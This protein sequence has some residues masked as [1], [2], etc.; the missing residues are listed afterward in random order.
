MKTVSFANHLQSKLRPISLSP[1]SN[2][3]L[4]STSHFSAKSRLTPSLRQ[5]RDKKPEEDIVSLKER[6]NSLLKQQRLDKRRIELLEKTVE[7]LEAK[8]QNMKDLLRNTMETERNHAGDVHALYQTL[9]ITDL[10]QQIEDLTQTSV[11]YRQRHHQAQQEIE[12]VKKTNFHYKNTIKRYR[13][14]LN[15]TLKKKKHSGEV[16][17]NSF[18]LGN[19]SETE[20]NHVGISYLAKQLNESKSYKV[21]LISLGKLER[22][23]NYLS[24]LKKAD[25]FIELFIKMTKAVSSLIKCERCTIFIV[26]PSI[27]AR[28]IKDFGQSSEFIGKIHIE[29]KLML[30]HTH[31]DSSQ[32]NPIFKSCSEFKYPMRYHDSIAVPILNN[33]QVSIVIQC[34][35]KVSKNARKQ[36][37]SHVD[38]IIIKMIGFFMITNVHL[39]KFRKDGEVKT[40]RADQ[41]IHMV[42]S[43]LSSL[44]HRYLANSIR[45]FIP[46]YTGF[47]SI[48]IVF[49]DKNTSELLVLAHDSYGEEFYTDCVL[50]FS[51][52]TGFTGKVYHSN[53]M[54][55]CDYPKLSA[56]YN[57]E[58]DNASGA[59]EVRNIL[60]YPLIDWNKNTI[61]FIQFINRTTEN[62]EVDLGPV[63]Q[64]IGFCIASAN[65]ITE[66]MNLTIETKRTLKKLFH[67]L[68]TQSDKSEFESADLSVVL[69]SLRIHA[70]ELSQRSKASGRLLKK[71]D[72]SKNSP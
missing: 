20:K 45:T 18:L 72:L 3:F 5:I 49:L 38:E 1:S 71:I 13:D 2:K 68:D 16:T 7:E 61:G 41:V 46:A 58:L 23:Y 39:L 66:Q 9:F 6:T 36:Y 65:T 31:K 26:D 59:P 47:D 51:N 21:N 69:S 70:A 19:S 43:F 56:I 11:N 17:P 8:I 67:S 50:R 28:Y 48:G 60:I 12:T 40:A 53:T 35:G 32:E 24:E 10:R 62:I 64:L 57:P 30:I 54:I 37:F 29:N 22:V 42:N 4:R 14:M 44:S 27:Q 25:N 63:L 15:E 34:F 33:N 55:S 52:T